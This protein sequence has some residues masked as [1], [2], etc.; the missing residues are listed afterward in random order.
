ML[1][2]KRG[3]IEETAC[4]RGDSEGG[5]EVVPVRAVVLGA[6]RQV[7]RGLILDLRR[8]RTQAGDVDLRGAEHVVESVLACLRT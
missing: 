5:E 4:V 6:L 1:R 7:A 8:L 3:E 2:E